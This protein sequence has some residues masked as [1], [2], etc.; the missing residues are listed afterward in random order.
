MPSSCFCHWSGAG[1]RCHHAPTL[2]HV[3]GLSLLAWL[4]FP[5]FITEEDVLRV[6][7]IGADMSATSIWRKATE[8]SVRV[9][10]LETAHNHGPVESNSGWALVKPDLNE[11]PDPE[12]SDDE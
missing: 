7:S 4:N 11:Y 10:A 1:A 2:N 6:G 5:E 9:D 8:V 12:N 3:E